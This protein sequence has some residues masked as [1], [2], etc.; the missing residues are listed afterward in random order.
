[1][2]KQIE[3]L[4]EVVRDAARDRDGKRITSEEE[5]RHCQVFRERSPDAG[6]LRTGPKQVYSRN[7]QSCVRGERRERKS[8]GRVGLVRGVYE[9]GRERNKGNGRG[10]G[11]GRLNSPLWLGG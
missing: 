1:M 11:R 3:N 8:G 9:S 4:L 2:K 6:R 7:C 10:R 5:R